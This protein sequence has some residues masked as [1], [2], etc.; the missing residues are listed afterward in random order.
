M[1]ASIWL[2]FGTHICSL[3]TNS[4]FKYGVNLITIHYQGVIS[5]FR[6]EAKANF[7]HAYGVNC[8]KK[9]GKS[10]YAARLKHQ[11]STFWWF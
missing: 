11:G 1:H 5:H 2:K 8:F 7:C 3:R 10:Q 9:Q 4:N 6:H